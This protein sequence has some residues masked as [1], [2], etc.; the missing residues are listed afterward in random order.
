MPAA[1]N[2]LRLVVPT[3]DEPDQDHEQEKLTDRAIT[4][5]ISPVRMSGPGI[6]WLDTAE[7]DPFASD[8]TGG[9]GWT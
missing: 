1:R 3:H 6:S 9:T 4:T 5:S 7:P 2:G 8:T